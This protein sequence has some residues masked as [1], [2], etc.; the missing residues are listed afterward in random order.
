[1][2]VGRKKKVIWAAYGVIHKGAI[3]AHTDD[4]QMAI[5]T[6]KGDAIASAPYAI[7]PDSIIAKLYIKIENS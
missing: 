3:L 5:F 7:F 4:G 6:L 1:M 2:S